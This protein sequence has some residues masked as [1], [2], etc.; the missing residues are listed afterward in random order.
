MKARKVS[1]RMA[2]LQI[3]IHYLIQTCR[4]TPPLLSIRTAE[5][6]KNKSGSHPKG[7]CRSTFKNA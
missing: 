6:E 2:E 7:N 4:K 5:Y 3:R 1:K